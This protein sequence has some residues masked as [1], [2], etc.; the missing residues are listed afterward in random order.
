MEKINETLQK[1]NKIGKYLARFIL[2]KKGK[3]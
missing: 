2:K 1:I 3:K